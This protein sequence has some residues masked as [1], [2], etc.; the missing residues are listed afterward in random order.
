MQSHGG[1]MP[2]ID[3]FYLFNK[4]RLTLLISPKELL[5]ACSLF[6]SLNVPLQICTYNDIKV[7]QS[8]DYSQQDD[9]NDNISKYVSH[10]TGVTVGMLAKKLG[11]SAL[12]SEIKVNNCLKEGLL[13]LD[14][15]IEG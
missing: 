5:K 11:V 15:R 10:E 13:C 1:M 12:I 9:F 7:I 14:D 6:S 8:L 4:K 2:L 3:L